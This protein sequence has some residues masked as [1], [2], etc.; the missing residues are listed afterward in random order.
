MPGNLVSENGVMPV[1][2]VLF[3]YGQVLSGPPD[4]AAWARMCAITRLS[5]DALHSGYWAFRHDYDRGAL[6]GQ[7]YWQEVA[8]HAG[9]A[10]DAAQV[11]AL[12][13]AD[14]DLWTQLNLP[15]VQW[16]ARL[17]RAGMRTGILSNIG[18]AIAEGIRGRLPWL[19]GFDHRTWSYAL[20]MAKPEAAIYLATAESLKTPPARI[21]F[22]D[23]L[24]RNIAAAEGVGMLAIRYA[25]HAG[26]EHE[27]RARGFGSLIDLGLESAR[28]QTMSP[29][30]LEDAAVPVA[31]EA[32]SN[33]RLRTV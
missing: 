31:K 5:E 7:A 4:P 2:A 14:V 30:S 21:L 26:F 23:D 32:V 19:A 28:T 8:V 12:L 22:I 6:S 16:A 3:D 1:D 33:S 24:E 20:G 27:M 13:E 9:V 17:Q 10:F 18:D 29:R 15:M 25:D 11:A